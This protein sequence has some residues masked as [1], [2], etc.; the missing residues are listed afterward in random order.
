MVALGIA[1]E[2]LVAVFKQELFKTGLV[3]SNDTRVELLDA[4]ER[5][6]ASP[7]HVL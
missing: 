1:L 4:D 7:L 3:H 5:K 6:T 2:P